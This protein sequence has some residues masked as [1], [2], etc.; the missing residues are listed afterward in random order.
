MSLS[1]CVSSGSLS[2]SVRTS[3]RARRARLVVSP[4]DGVV[5][6]VPR[7]ADPGQVAA[8]VESRAEWIRQAERR[9]AEALASVGTRSDLDAGGRPVVVP[10]R[11]VEEEWRVAYQASPARRC[12]ARVA[13][14]QWLLVSGPV[15]AADSVRSALERWLAD[16]ARSEVVGWLTVLAREHRVTL[17]GVS[18]RAQRSRW[19]SCSSSGR[20]SVNRN[21]LFLPRHLVEHVLLHELCHRLEMSHSPRFWRLLEG[22]DPSTAERRVELRTAWKYVPSWA[23]T[24]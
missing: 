11:A 18:V 14:P 15:A 7:R 13:G 20:V 5:V 1:D 10:L 4:R 3:S 9:I 22:V 24:S 6:V 17:A 16:R 12:A 8:F 21:L 23:Q 19:A 2:Y